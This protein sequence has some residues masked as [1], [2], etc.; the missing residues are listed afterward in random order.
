MDQHGGGWLDFGDRWVCSAGI[1]NRKL[2]GDVLRSFYNTYVY[3]AYTYYT[4]V[5]LAI[6]GTHWGRIIFVVDDS[7]SYT[8]ERCDTSHI[9]PGI[10]TPGCG[11]DI[12]LWR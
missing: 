6:A 1:R 2:S 3:D 11:L 9:Y 4:Y 10:L 5:L 8:R 7:S 12:G